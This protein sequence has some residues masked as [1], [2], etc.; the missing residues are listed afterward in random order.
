MA[1]ILPPHHHL[2]LVELAGR[3]MLGEDGLAVKVRARMEHA[4]GY[5]GWSRGEY[6]D[7]LRTEPELRT[8]ESGELLHV[9]VPAA[10][11]GSYEIVCEVE[12]LPGF[13]GASVEPALEFQQLLRARLPHGAEDPAAH[14]LGGDLHLSGHMVAHQLRQVILSR[15]LVGEYHVVSYP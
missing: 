13:Q 15:F 4:R 7:L 2:L 3:G 11:M 12:V 8:A 9:L 6:L 10:G 14:M 5:R 1:R